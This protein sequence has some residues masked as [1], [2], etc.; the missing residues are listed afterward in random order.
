MIETALLYVH[1]L[2]GSTALL[3]AIIPVVTK[4]GGTHHVRA[5]RVYALAMTDRFRYGVATRHS[6]RRHFL[7]D[8]RL[9]QLLLGICGLALRPQPRPETAVGRLGSGQH[10]GGHGVVDVGI[11]C[12]GWSIRGF[13]L[14][15]SR[16]VWDDCGCSQRVGLA[17]SP[18]LGCFGAPTNTTAPDKHARRHYSYDHGGD[19]RQLRLRRTGMDCLDCP[20]SGDQSDYHL[21][22]FQVGPTNLTTNMI[23]RIT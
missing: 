14:D 16:G 3:A 17:V 5:G 1:I 9:L 6:W 21:V 23:V 12:R 11:R 15:R 2:A 20:Y 8:Y 18:R 22:E 13:D 19:G 10:H 7:A 4:K